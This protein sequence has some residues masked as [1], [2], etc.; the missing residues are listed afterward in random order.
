MSVTT[1][2]EDSTDDGQTEADQRSW[3]K[4]IGSTFLSRASKMLRSASVLILL[5]SLFVISIV[6][7]TARFFLASSMET[8]DVLFIA[9]AIIPALIMYKVRKFRTL[10]QQLITD[11]HKEIQEHYPAITHPS[12]WNLLLTI[13]S[14][15]LLSLIFLVISWRCWE[16]AGLEG[17]DRATA[18]LA[19]VGG[20]GLMVS[21]VVAYRKQAS[22]ERSE[23]QHEFSTAA[24]LISSDQGTSRIAGVYA[25]KNIGDRYPQLRQEVAD[26]L[27]TFL[28]ESKEDN[29]AIEAEIIHQFL[30]LLSV[31]N[32]DRWEDI[33]LDLHGATLH[34]Y[35][36]LSKCIIGKAY[37][38]NTKFNGGQMFI[39]TE[40][41]GF[42]NFSKAELYTQANFGLA[43]FSEGVSFQRTQFR[44]PAIFTDTHFLEGTPIET[45]AIIHSPDTGSKTAR[46]PPS[47]DFTDAHFY[48]YVAFI[49]AVFNTP[50]YFSSPLS[51]RGGEPQKPTVVQ[52]D[53]NVDFRYT[54]FNGRVKFQGVEF[55]H[56]VSFQQAFFSCR[57]NLTELNLVLEKCGSPKISQSHLIRHPH[58]NR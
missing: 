2:S 10:N 37:F 5:Q 36:N 29:S 50:V 43:T 17:S 30:H 6:L 27:C 58:S 48:T 40:F 51:D 18:S 34:E 54:E 41:K 42:A 15:S 47:A 33:D 9:T 46:Y 8:W 38:Q 19:I 22:S 4:L 32:P 35:F 12:Q 49:G 26:L 7:L 44:C 56:S 57:D 31:R 53:S 13:T 24:Q 55:N 3:L 14:I 45:S 16:L 52:F 20:L 25:L 1:D 28:R 11:I 39:K 21:L 23:G